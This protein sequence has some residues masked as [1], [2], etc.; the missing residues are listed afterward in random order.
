LVA[1]MAC[2]AGGMLW[3]FQRR[4]WLGARKRSGPP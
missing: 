3:W 1:A 2:I 4:G